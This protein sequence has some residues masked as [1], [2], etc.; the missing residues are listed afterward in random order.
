MAELVHIRRT[1]PSFRR[2]TFFRGQPML[3]GAPKDVIWLK[4]D[5]S[6]MGPSDW[7]DG[8]VRC[9]GM[10][11]SGAGIVDVGSRGDALQD[12]DFLLLLN[13]YHEAIPFAAPAHEGGDGW[14][15]LVDTAGARPSPVLPAG[16]AWPL[17]GR[18]LVLLHRPAARP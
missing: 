7:N 10:L 17:Q 8:N 9:L 11:V 4:P 1:H 3:D 5:G 2:R 12:D 6:E 13:A 15:C 16:E 14:T 18:S